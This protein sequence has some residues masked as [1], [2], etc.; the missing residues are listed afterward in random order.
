MLSRGTSAL[1]RRDKVWYVKEIAEDV[2]GNL[3]TNYLGLLM[4]P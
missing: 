4:E 2:E 1:S 3:S